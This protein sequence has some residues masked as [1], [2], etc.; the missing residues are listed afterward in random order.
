[1]VV[2]GQREN[3]SL[4]R[5]IKP[6]DYLAPP[7]D[8]MKLAC[9]HARRSPEPAS[10]KRPISPR[11]ARH[12]MLL[13]PMRAD[14]ASFSRSL[15]MPQRFAPTPG[16]RRCVLD[17]EALARFR[18]GYWHG[19]SAWRVYK[20][21]AMMRRTHPLSAVSSIT[22]VGS[23]LLWTLPS[24][25]HSPRFLSSH[26]P[27]ISADLPSSCPVPRVETSRLELTRANEAGGGG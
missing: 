9:R 26:D 18:H 15:G 16:H 21:L 12:A 11:R 24:Q 27:S 20:A 17:H 22:P 3:G 23:Q 6:G 25:N 19:P 14:V 10:S 5:L 13:L 8:A 4:N 2:T 7:V 1:M